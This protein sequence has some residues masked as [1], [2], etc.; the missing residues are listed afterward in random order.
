VIASQALITRSYTLVSE[1][2]MLNLLP[3]MEI[4]YPSDTKGQLYIGVVNKVL[5][6]GCSLVVLYFRSGHKMESAYGLAITVTMLMTTILISVY[7]M[8]LRKQKLISLV[9]LIV[10]GM[11]E[12]VFFVSSLTKFMHGGYVTV[13]M[14]IIL[15]CLMIVWYRGT[16][17]EREHYNHLNLLD[18][19]DELGRL[20]KD[21]EEPLMCHN[22][23]YLENFHDKETIDRDILYSIL[24]KDPKRA[25]AYWF[26]SVDV[27]D[28][29]D[30]LNYEVETY[31]TDYIFRV[32]LNI[33]FKCDQ[34][35]NIYLRQLVQDLQASGEL[36]V[37]T[38][39]YSIYEPS[40][41]GTFKFCIIHKE[42]PHKADLD[43]LDRAILKIKYFVRQLIG[44]KAQWYGLTTSTVIVEKVPMIVES[45]VPGKRIVRQKK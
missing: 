18:H 42:V 2:I 21:K 7:L 28:E 35:I 32:K 14:T 12:A 41:V 4:H 29:P 20:S 25:Q 6:V 5:W 30:G 39:K 8:K 43:S 19:L 38:K 36:P 9:V 34:R 24:D 33:G 31:G 45:G 13:I 40:T 22:L 23:V 3:H 10:F 26:V 44:S 16:Q 27:L 17:L 1:A 37:Q 15:L 11:I